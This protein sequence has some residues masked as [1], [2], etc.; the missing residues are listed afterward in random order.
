M[1]DKVAKGEAS[2]IPDSMEVKTEAVP[3]EEAEEVAVP[4]GFDAFEIGQAF[5]GKVVSA[6]QFGVFVDIQ[7]GQ[8]ALIPRSV[9]SRGGYEKLKG[10]VKSETKVTVEIIGMNAENQTISAKYIPANFNERAD[11]STLQGQDLSSKFYQA[12]VVS[13]H[14]FGIFAELDKQ[15]F[16]MFRF[17]LQTRQQHG[18]I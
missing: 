11:I 4:A 15:F 14:D 10:M 2:E 6:K 7:G 13:T 18:G 3:V 16:G 1:E 9:L 17:A 12:V 5:E 8:N